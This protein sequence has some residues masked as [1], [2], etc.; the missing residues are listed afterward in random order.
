MQTFPGR[1]SATRHSGG[2]TLLEVMVVIVI[3]GIIFGFATLSVNSV[4]NRESEE[5]A[6]RIVALLKLAADESVINSVDYAL[7]LLRSKY[8]F[9]TVAADG[10]LTPLPP[11]EQILKARELPDGTRFELILNGE[12]VFLREEAQEGEPPVA[13][14]V[15]S[16][17]ELTPFTLDIKNSEDEI[18]RIEGDF[19]GNLVYLGAPDED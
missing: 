1:L 17:G 15:L 10:Q 7:T 8:E 3:I 4:G 9:A 2:F 19:A 5:E 18:F 11:E 12:E 16:S 13:I 14:W 6:K